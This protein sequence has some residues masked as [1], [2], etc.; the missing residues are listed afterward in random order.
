M[1]D[2]P[3]LPFAKPSLS[4]AAIAEVV[5]CLQSGWITTGPRVAKF[6]QMLGEYHGGRR[7]LCL[8]SATAGLQ[9]ALQALALQEGDEVI[10]TPL[11]FVAT[12]NTI[13]LAGGTPVLVDIDPRTLNIDASR[14]EAAITPRTKVIMPVHFAGLPCD[15]D[16]IYALAKKHGLRVVEDCAHAIGAEHDGR[17]LGSFG[18]IQVMSFHPNKNM[19]TG[20]GGCVVADD[21]HIV[22]QVALPRHR[23]QR[24]QPLRQIRQPEL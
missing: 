12:L 20:E 14:I 22:S 6:E 2:E 13:V 10:T 8:S 16:A 3:F 18:D 15:M 23:P 5:E 1:N 24:L 19:T 21:E 11:T 17:R 4:E 9:L 7:A